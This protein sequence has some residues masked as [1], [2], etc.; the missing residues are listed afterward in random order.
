[1]RKILLILSLLAGALQALADKPAPAAA[2]PGDQ[3][4][5]GQA[6]AAEGSDFIRVDED[7]KAA[8]LQTA[9]IRY[10]KDGTTVDLVGAVHMA[11]QAYY[12]RLNE[13]FAQY[14]A[15]LFEMVGG[16]RMVEGAI[17]EPDEAD[18]QAR[19]L[20]QV[21]GTMS[22]FLQLTGQ[23]E[24]IDYGKEN[25]VHADL[26]AEEFARKQEERGES[27]LSFAFAAAQNVEPGE[28]PQPNLGRML[29][30]LLAGDAN[31][32]KLEMMTSL[33]QGDDQIAA[34]AGDNVIVADRNDKCLEVL[35]EQLEAGHK[36]LA[37]FY[38][39][40]HFPDMEKRLLE[41]GFR[42][43]GQDWITAWDVPKP[44]PAP[45]VEEG[46]EAPAG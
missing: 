26:T 2:T 43:E 6:A 8:R 31:G 4:A 18:A 45:A 41:D 39:A 5:A 46:A 28:G 13:I 23:L 30:A 15:V 21:V 12:K 22:R 44:Q 37:I 14:E 11:D 25:F 27:I 36:K 17:P 42:K 20:R 16:E 19:M 32:L 1:M 10:E 29:T 3:E 24:E 35:A 7:E 38:G 33:G 9:L 40:A 34:I